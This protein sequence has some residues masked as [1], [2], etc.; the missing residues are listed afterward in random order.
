M[1]GATNFY[2]SLLEIDKVFLETGYF[3]RIS[4]PAKP[5]D[6]I[7]PPSYSFGKVKE[8]FRESCAID[9]EFAQLGSI[10][11]NRVLPKIRDLERGARTPEN[12]EL[13][14]R[15][16]ARIEAGLDEIKNKKE[17]A[18][19]YGE[20]LS[21]YIT[22]LCGSAAPGRPH[23]LIRMILKNIV[24]RKAPELS[25]QFIFRA[26]AK[27]RRTITIAIIAKR[28][29]VYVL[30]VKGLNVIFRS[31]IDFRTY[32][33]S[34]EGLALQIMNIL[35]KNGVKLADVT[36]VVCGGGD[37]GPL[38]DGIFVLTEKVRD[39]SWKR[40]HNSS[41]NRGALVASELVQ[42][43]RSQKGHT[44]VNASLCSPLSFSTLATQEL[45]F[46]FRPES[47]AMQ[48]GFRGY[49]KVT[50]LKSVAA[51][52]SN[53]KGLKQ[54]ELNLLVLTLDEL[55]AS[56]VR[57]IGPRIV[58]ELTAQDANKILINFD[59]SKIVEY[60]KKENFT[61]P[62]HFRLASVDMGT[63]VL[64]VCELLMIAESGKI[65]RKLASS[66]YHIVDSYATSVAMALEMCSSGSFPE[67]PHFIVVTSMRASDPYFYR[68][69][70]KIRD[71]I[72]NPLTP[73]LCL[74]SLEH[75]YLIANHLFEMYVNPTVGESRLNYGFEARSMKQA[76][77]VLESSGTLSET[78]SFSSLLDD[79]TAKIEKG[80][81]EP[82]SVVLVGADNE[83]ALLAAANAREYGLVRKLALIGDEGD[84]LAAIERS[85]AGLSLADD[86]DIWIV[87]T[88][89]LA[90]DYEEKK[91]SMAEEFRKFLVDHRNFVIMKG[92]I[93]TS[94]ILHVALS[95]YKQD[96]VENGAKKDQ[97][98]KLAT[99]TGL[100]VFPDKR[101]LVLSDPAV[102]PAFTSATKLL[103]A[104]ENQLDVVRRVVGPDLLLKLAIITAVEKE[105]S[106]IPSTLVA[107][108]AEGLAKDLEQKYGPLIVEGPLSFDLAT[109]PEV[110]EEKHYQG[111]IVGD[112][113]CLVATEINTAN[114]LY[115]MLS[116][117]MGSLGLMIDIGGII[118]AGPGTTPIVLTSRGDT[119]Q[120]KFHSILLALA[121]STAT[122]ARIGEK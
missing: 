32:G 92:S 114:V 87:P 120:T 4:L 30:A 8:L 119:A 105:T 59:F 2:D 40:L 80:T 54:E 78:F 97:I 111:K 37:L 82:A 85:N 23:P 108:E 68:L 115:K 62:P 17:I 90:V 107:A 48:Q 29:A 89:R 106:A 103:A 20:L 99:F 69:F 72:D 21:L 15:Y 6:Q 121:Y 91:K 33:Y 112:A 18:N 79:V 109:A 38:P 9:A 49:V 28:Y 47:R 43:L 65:S 52:I 14:S 58:R 31:E 95:I 35:I 73:V 26:F 94:A 83:D 76:L 77:Q 25:K 12:N 50:P 1:N 56:V 13:L 60:L 64:E 86:P 63:G 104:M 55:F 84:I 110:A 70:T 93:D 16:L 67:R 71:R 10:L 101:F 88:D 5:G 24:S 117:T 57:K 100:F 118:T 53:M 7:S 61:I 96:A 11:R 44:P 39:E 75:E 122:L 113:N 22:S 3:D 98:P 51:I 66:L 74:D 41:L 19:V 81:I 45:N 34:P 46:L 27:L 36:D 116:K 42:L 102:N